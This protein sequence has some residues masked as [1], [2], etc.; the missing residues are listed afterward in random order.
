MPVVPA[1]CMAV[2]A[3][4]MLVPI[5]VPEVSTVVSML[6]IVV[7]TPVRMVV[8]PVP[9]A[10]IEVVSPVCMLVKAVLMAVAAVSQAVFSPSIDA[11]LRVSML[12]KIAATSESAPSKAVI[13]AD[14]AASPALVDLASASLAAVSS[15][16]PQPNKLANQPPTEDAADFTP[17]QVSEA[18]E[19]MSP[20]A[21]EMVS[22]TAEKVLLNQ[23]ATPPSAVKAALMSAHA[24]AAQEDTPAT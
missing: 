15:A 13:R 23:V 3:V 10:V 21:V 18:Q 4:S 12:S 19:A 6:V 20:T 7:F 16:L 14:L 24:P 11:P 2:M 9:M 8:T 1:V 5:A 17:S 22:P